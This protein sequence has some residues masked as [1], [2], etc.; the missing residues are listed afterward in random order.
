MND[1]GG[2]AF[3][4]GGAQQSSTGGASISTTDMSSNG[5]GALDFELK[6]LKFLRD[7]EEDYITRLTR[8]RNSSFFRNKLLYNN[9][10]LLCS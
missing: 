1:R 4:P 3:L 7:A 8:V 9:F 5:R 6:W 10:L 2:I